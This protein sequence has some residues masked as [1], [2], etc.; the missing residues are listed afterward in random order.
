[1]KD[2]CLRILMAKKAI[3]SSQKFSVDK[4]INQWS[5]LIEK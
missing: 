4:I 1:M 3:E 5:D 2:D